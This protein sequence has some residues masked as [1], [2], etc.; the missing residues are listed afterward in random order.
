MPS[1]SHH[2]RAEIAEQH[3]LAG[4]AEE[5]ATLFVVD[6]D[7]GVRAALTALAGLEGLRCLV[8]DSAETFLSCPSPAAPHCLVLD[9]NLPGFGAL[10][11]QAQMAVRCRG[12][13]IIFMTEVDAVPT[14]VRAMKPDT[15]EFLARPFDEKVLL[16][17]VRKAISRSAEDRQ[18]EAALR[19]LRQRYASLTPRETEVMHLVVTGLQNKQVARRLDVAEITVKVHRS[20]A[21]EKMRAASFADLVK[22]SVQLQSE[23]EVAA[24]RAA[25]AL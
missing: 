8:F 5:T 24:H 3:T 20:R 15:L 7:L 17:A 23:S 14:S 25:S 1:L 22:M 21:M 12:V 11:L 10:A 13:P 18:R 16:S 9:I 19:Q 6:Q 2:S 4:L